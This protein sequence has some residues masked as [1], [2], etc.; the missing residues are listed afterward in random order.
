MNALHSW[1]HSTKVEFVQILPSEF[2][3][4]LLASV[5]IH[6]WWPSDSKTIS[7]GS[8]MCL[9]LRILKLYLHR[10][11][12]DFALPVGVLGTQLLSTSIPINVSRH[13]HRPNGNNISSSRAKEHGTK[14]VL[15]LRTTSNQRKHYGLTNA[16]DESQK[17]QSPSFRRPRW[18]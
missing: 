18:T 12:I 8:T 15:V 5:N 7:A 2:W 11:D 13:S 6:C 10:G 3:K 9:N 14:S 4:R 1:R 16:K 17:N